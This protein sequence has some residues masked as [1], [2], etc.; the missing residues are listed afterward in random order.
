MSQN[1]FASAASESPDLKVA[2]AQACLAVNQQ[3]SQQ[4]PGATA[5]LVIAFAAGFTASEFESA[6]PRISELTDGKAV[7]AVTCQSLVAAGKEIENAK[8]ISLWAASMPDASITPMVLDVI[9]TDG[10]AELVGVPAE[11]WEED[12]VLMLLTEAYSFPA[13]VLLAKLN[14]EHPTVKVFGGVADGG[15]Q[16]H[17]ARLMIGEEIFS[18]GAVAVRISG[19]SVKTVVSQGCR[20]IGDAYIVT[21]SERNVVQ[22][23]GGHPAMEVLQR[24]YATLPTQDKSRVET[25]LHLGI[26]M[27]ELKDRFEFGDFL[28]RN[29]VGI[30]E[31]GQS[32]TIGD[33]V[34]KG[35]TVKFHIRDQS[36]ASAELESMLRS[37]QESAACSAAAL[38]FTCNGRGSQLFDVPDHDAAMVT[39]FLGDI[40]MAGFFAAGEFGRVGDANFLHGFTA[41]IA[42]FE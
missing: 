13:D 33:Y 7:L 4:S 42:L 30:D 32:I 5:D 15:Y 28:I 31:S 20:P 29:V 23:L 19:V 38:V 41:S 34:R 1:R 18:T 3:L 27:T 11:G 9:Q 12:S 24:V 10:N 21:Q 16:P 22:T 8:G 2:V 36:S 17:E 6:M 40:P 37:S 14:Q 35:R 26:A 25:G 39:R